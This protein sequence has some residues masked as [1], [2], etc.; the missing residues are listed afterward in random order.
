VQKYS[1]Q[2]VVL[3]RIQRISR[4]R[5]P[6]SEIRRQQAG[7]IHLPETQVVQVQAEKRKIQ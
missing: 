2:N 7:E 6:E 5:N 1:R 3:Q 4:T